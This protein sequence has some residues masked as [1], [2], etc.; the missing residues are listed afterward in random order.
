MHIFETSSRRHNHPDDLGGPVGSL[1]RAQEQNHIQL[2]EAQSLQLG[3]LCSLCLREHFFQECSGPKD[4]GLAAPEMRCDRSQTETQTS[5]SEGLRWT[6]LLERF[7]IH[8]SRA[9]RPPP[10][11]LDTRPFWPRATCSTDVPCPPETGNEICR[12]H[13]LEPT[14][15][16]ECVS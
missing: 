5:P 3:V 9:T 14:Q 8:L 12:V 4:W 1:K 15:L 16:F 10:L 11:G 13:T 2:D 7:I 6:R